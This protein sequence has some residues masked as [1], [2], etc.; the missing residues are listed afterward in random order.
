MAQSHAN[1]SLVI[2]FLRYDSTREKKTCR[3]RQCSDREKGQ[4]QRITAGSKT[5]VLPPPKSA[6]GSIASYAF[7][8]SDNVSAS[9]AMHQLSEGI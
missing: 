6:Y 4:L 1:F 7:S 9:W 2:A 5:S 3:M 8:L